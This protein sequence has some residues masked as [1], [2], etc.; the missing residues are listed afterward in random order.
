[1]NT[2]NRLS[3]LWLALAVVI[4]IAIGTFYAHHFSGNR[5]SIINSGS[6]KLNN[7]LY[8]IDDQYVDTIDMAD[9]VE[10]A[11]PQILSELDPHSTYISAKD[12]Q[13]ANDDLRG[14]FSGVGIEFVIRHDTLRVQNVISEGPA[15]QA[16]VLAGDKIVTVDD[17]VFTGKTLTNEEAMHRLKGPQGTKVKLGILRYGETD[18]RYVT[19]TRGEIP[20]KSVTAAYMLDDETGYIKIKNFGENTYYELLVALA[21]LAQD[22][23]QQLTIDLRGNT[24]GYLQSA[25]Q[26]ANEFL[27]KNMLIVYTEGR[28]SPREE[29]RSDGRG[30]YQRM[31][32]VILIDEGSASASEI[33][34]GAIQDNDRGTIIGRR[35]FGKGLVQKP[36]EFGDGSMM[37]LTIARYYTPS[38]RCIQKPYTNGM[39]KEYEED[40]LARYQH[41]EFFSQD[42]I[43]HEGPEY[44]TKNGR[45]VYGGGGITP[46]IFVPEDTTDYTSYYKEA[47]LSGLILQFGYDYTDQNRDKLKEY[48]DEASLLKYIKKQ[49]L[50]EQF[51]QYADKHGLKRR[52]LM[53]QKSRRLLEQYIYSR[54]I[55]NM[56][57]EEAWLQYLNED[58]PAVGEAL[59]LFKAGE[60]FPSAPSEEEKT[61]KKVA[62]G[63]DYRLTHRSYSIIARA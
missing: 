25:V 48:D 51:A 33:L 19:V 32:L 10:Q 39:D 56:L 21:Q 5:L 3:P 50:V 47:S 37:R 58:D 12:V 28:R 45:V 14:S 59:R 63:Y 60:A 7:L 30:S 35:S 8:I 16:G 44:H 43:K 1:M 36:V 20:M 46:D 53:I 52:N 6:N 13:T 26:I 9:L 11:M 57:S 62:M 15:E 49:N 31:P 42:S 41:G 27:P 24:G 38:G 29:F 55:Y 2:K 34:A 61:S 23:F 4:G 22:G 18:L 54:V 40:L 17:S